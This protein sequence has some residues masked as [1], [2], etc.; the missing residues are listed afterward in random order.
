MSDVQ[1]LTNQLELARKE[2]NNL[3]KLLL[4]L[5]HI[6]RKEVAD[7][8]RQLETWQCTNCRNSVNDISQPCS[9]A[10]DQSELLFKPI[11][12]IETNFPEKRCTPRQTTICR[13]IVAKLILEK[14][15]FTN[16]SHALEGLQ[17]FSHMWI[18]FYFD[19][20]DSKHNK[21]K[22]AVPRL[23]GTK[24]G[25]FATRSP[26]RPCPIG[27]S[28]V[29]IDRIK[30]NIIY[31]CGVDMVNGTPVLDIKPYIPQYDNPVLFNS[32]HSFNQPSEPTGLEESGLDVSSSSELTDTNEVLSRVMDGQE[33]LT[34]DQE[35][36]SVVGSLHYRVDQSFSDRSNTRIGEREAPDGEEEEPSTS[37][38]QGSKVSQP[39]ASH[40]HVRVPSWISQA[41]VAKLTVCFK[42]R[43]LTQLKELGAEWDK[44]NT[45][46]NVLQ[47]DPRS[48]YL[49]ERWGSHCYVFRIA[50]LCVSC[51]FNDDTHTVTV[52]QIFRNDGTEES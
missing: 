41:P 19:K 9:S 49:R 6:H 16:P 4:S 7:I 31:F 15:V 32:T 39:G 46:M 28:L 3:R 38:Q 44:K 48:V 20:N 18:L 27:L 21:A 35:V 11:G 52:Y 42:D 43:A 30:D 26:H 10:Q 34:L 33:N 29:K 14:D 40:G 17:E 23:N 22:V 25:V 1:R 37:G 51:K 24:T 2:I 13:D 5:N 12:S 45:I 47:E 36:E 8:Y 50:E